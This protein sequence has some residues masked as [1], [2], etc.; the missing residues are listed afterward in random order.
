MNV[1][2]DR[3]KPRVSIIM[4]AYNA[5][6]YIGQ[7]IESA[8]AQTFPDWELIVV[9]DCSTDDT[10]ACVQSYSDSRIRYLKNEKNSG[11]A[12]SRNRAIEAGRGEYVAFLDSDDVWLP[13]K[14]EA[15]IRQLDAGASI[16]YGAYYRIAADGKL[17]STVNVP[18]ALRYRDMLK[19]NFIGHLTGIYRKSRFPDLRFESGGHEDYV[20]WLRAVKI[21][22]EIHAALPGTPLANYRVLD[23]SLSA[24][25]KK[26]LRWQWRIYREVLKLS[27]GKS[28]Y[29]FIFYALNA[30]RKRCGFF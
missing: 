4:P 28:F 14:L 9:D 7:A 30:V 25:K 13:F 22:G 20:F 23:N 11:A 24:D 3:A 2:I 21:A 8:L 1:R 27:L 6:A 10:A 16:S 29:Y 12:Q 17:L 5:Q 18:H 15:Q 19:S 26:A